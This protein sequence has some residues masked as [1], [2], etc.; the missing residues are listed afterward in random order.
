VNEID[1]NKKPSLMINH[2]SDFIREWRKL[3]VD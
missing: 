1:M 2:T 3:P